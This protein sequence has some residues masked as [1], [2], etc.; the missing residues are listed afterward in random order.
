VSTAAGTRT[1][2]DG[3]LPGEESVL[4]LARHEN[5][6]VASL[7]LGRATRAHLLA[8]YG[9]AR[10]ADQVGDEAPGDRLAL[11]DELEA[12]LGRAF[13]GEPRHPVLRRLAPAVRALDLP[14]G[15]F[16]RLLEAN[17]RDQLQSSYE[18]F[19]DLEGYCEL[20]ANPVGELV[21]HV[22]R[23]A[24]PERI[25]LSDRVCTGLQLVE[26]WQDVAEDARRGRVYLPAEDLARFG[27][28]PS[29]L[30]GA[31]AGEPLRR[32]LAFEVERARALLDEGAPL[33]GSLRG[34]ARLAVAGYVAGGRA[35]ADAIA[36]AGYDVLPGA[37][38]A[39]GASRLRATARTY[40]M[41]R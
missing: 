26:H 41:G 31:H 9:F 4:P 10:L 34:R 7:P 35:N 40:R 13:A 39:T 24:T 30:V 1:E 19:A 33:V 32:L 29:D 38:K 37:P 6:S 5:F 28:E 18:T 12:E 21:L 8:I 23:A 15:P 11:L 20:S 22:F 25:A 27:V 14:R 36:A 2:P 3:R 16:E 17:R